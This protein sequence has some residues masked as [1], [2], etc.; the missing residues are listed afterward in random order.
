MLLPEFSS[1]MQHQNSYVLWSGIIR[2]MNKVHAGPG[3]K[4]VAAVALE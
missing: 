2:A 1:G 3:L 4:I